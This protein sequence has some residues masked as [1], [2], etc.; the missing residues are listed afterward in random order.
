TPVTGT[1]S[2]LRRPAGSP[3]MVLLLVENGTT[4]ATEPVVADEGYIEDG[5]ALWFA[6]YVGTTSTGAVAKGSNA[7]AIGDG[8]IAIGDGAMAIGESAVA[9]GIRAKVCGQA[10][11]AQGRDATVYGRFA[12]VVGDAQAPVKGR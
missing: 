12:V 4:G 11:V 8:A 9:I 5:T 1:N 7:I 2:L 6:A 3:G 10:S